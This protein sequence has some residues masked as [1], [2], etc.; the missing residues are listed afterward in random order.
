[1]IRLPK[2]TAL[3]MLGPPIVSASEHATLVRDD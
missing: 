1:M 2:D 3:L